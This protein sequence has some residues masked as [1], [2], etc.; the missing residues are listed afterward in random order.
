MS[1]APEPD[2]PEPEADQGLS[3]FYLIISCFF[4]NLNLCK[5]NL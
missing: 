5:C 1:D 4:F 3:K 2:A